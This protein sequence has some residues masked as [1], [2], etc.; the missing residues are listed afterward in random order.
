MKKLILLI[1]P[2][3]S[4]VTG[5]SAPDIQ[6]DYNR[7]IDFTR[8]TTFGFPNHLKQSEVK[9]G[10]S[11]VVIKQIRDAIVDALRQRGFS[12]TE[13]NPD[14]LVAYTTEHYEHIRIQPAFDEKWMGFWQSEVTSESWQEGKLIVDIIDR[15]SG[16]VVWRGWTEKR[17]DDPREINE[18][19]KT[20][21]QH[22]FADFPP[23]N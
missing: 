6:T 11:P 7:N 1:L 21:I 8:Y 4:L 13:S 19:I 14:I 2:L 12:F 23:V 18:K 22:L 16:S 5:C 15:E 10:D 3:L 9:P 17:I 20:V